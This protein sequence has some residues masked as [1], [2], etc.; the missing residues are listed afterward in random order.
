MYCSMACMTKDKQ[1]F[2]Q[3]ECGIDDNPEDQHLD[4]N[5]LKILLHILAQFDGNV[6]EMKKF[7]NSNRKPSC[8]FDFDFS[9]KDDPMFEKNMILATLSMS[10]N[11]NCAEIGKF[12]CLT[13]HHRFIMKHPKLRSMW[14]SSHKKFLD[15]LL[16][17]FLDVEDVKG[18]V[19]CFVE[20]DMNLKEA[21]YDLIDQ[22]TDG[23]T[24]IESFFA[25]S[26]ASVNDPYLS[27]VNQS[28]FPN[29]CIKFVNNKHVWIVIRPVKSG[30]QLFMFRGPGI[31]YVT[32]R[33]QRQQMMLEYFGFRCD[34]DGCLNNWPT[35][36]T[37]KKLSNEDKLAISCED[38]RLNSRIDH[39]QS[40]EYADYVKYATKIQAMAKYFPCYDSIYLEHKW[41]F[42]IYRLARPAKWFSSI[43]TTTKDVRK[44]VV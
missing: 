17:K 16:C 12:H 33:V 34:C 37:M 15:N 18:L 36:Q 30:E 42:N 20:V 27:L 32:P 14:M 40:K 22:K 3:F 7:L 5:P 8:V 10:H 11:M 41:M 38:L 4:Y 9:N 35:Q 23:A 24:K 25:N 44:N 39:N 31:K 6:D 26:V 2:H 1:K 28:C 21:G 13:T 19:S 29:I 43:E